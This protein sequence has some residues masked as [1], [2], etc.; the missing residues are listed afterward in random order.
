MEYHIY[1]PSTFPTDDFR[2]VISVKII[3]QRIDWGKMF[4][5]LVP[6]GTLHCN[7]M[8][9]KINAAWLVG[10]VSLGTGQIAAS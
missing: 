1:I 2:W 7:M 6:W 10:S 9:R 4:C 3:R 8:T 5:Y